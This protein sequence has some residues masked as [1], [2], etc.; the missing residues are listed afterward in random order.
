MRIDRGEGV[1]ANFRSCI[2]Q[3]IEEAR[4]TSIWHSNQP[5]ISDQSQLNMEFSFFA[6]LT[7]C[8][9]KRFDVCRSFKVFVAESPSTA[10]ENFYRLIFFQ[11]RHDFPGG[12]IFYRRTD[13]KLDRKIIPSFAVH[14][15]FHTVPAIF[16]RKLLDVAIVG[17]NI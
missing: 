12:E 1:S 7:R 15:T 4:L 8:A 6:R 3:G 11:K 10:F 2:G 13:R 17:E 16:S 5:S 9:F 14:A